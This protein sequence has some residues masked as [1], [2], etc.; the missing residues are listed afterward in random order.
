MDTKSYI[1][2]LDLSKAIPL[3]NSR[4]LKT[5]DP[6]QLSHLLNDVMTESRRVKSADST[7][8]SNFTINRL[9]F[10]ESQILGAV[11][12]DSIHVTSETLESVSIVMPLRGGITHTHNNKEQMVKPG[13]GLVTSPGQKINMLWAPNTTAFSIHV[14]E[15]TLRRY[16]TD[17]F[18][19]VP[20]KNISFESLFN[21]E[22][23]PSFALREMLTRICNE[24]VDPNSLL[25]RGVTAPAVE[26]Q[27]LLTLLDVLK[28][29]YSSE[30][31]G[32]AENYRPKHIKRAIEYIYDNSKSS[33]TM[34]DL[35]KHCDVSTRT[36]Q[37]GFQ[38]LYG[39]GIM[40]YVRRFKLNQIR[41]ALKKSHPNTT[42]VSDVAAQ[43][44]C[45]HVSNFSK[46]YKALFGEY[47][48][49]TLAD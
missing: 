38:K 23:S 9:A 16:L 33:I 36:L 26:E 45:T 11:Y 39:I 46:N 25:A 2:S 8:N 20:Y 40:T 19:I 49:K 18:K 14:P 41:E 12:S 10:T 34:A 6:E 42:T 31:S 5:N 4:A 22:K 48:S 28:S 3:R 43:W 17:Y 47:P 15:S 13:Q 1:A 32:L 35:V 24:V 30:I 37:D 27:L 44:G 21:W 7:K 29:N